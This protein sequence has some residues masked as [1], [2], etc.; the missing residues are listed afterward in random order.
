MSNNPKFKI[1]AF[2]NNATKLQE[3][4]EKRGGVAK[5]KSINLSNPGYSWSTP[6]LNEDGTPY[7]KPNWQCG[8]TPEIVTDPKEIGIIERELYKAIPVGL[9]RGDGLSFTLT[10][11][12][13]RKVHKLQEQC[14]K[15]HGDSFIERAVLDIEGASIGV[16]YTKSQTSL[17]D[18]I[19]Q[20]KEVKID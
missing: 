18:W 3:W 19:E 11:A 2:T 5:W 8:N 17:F 12:A 15:K 13:T 10:P 4:C 9:Q 16:Y 6:A 1:E 20:H 7:S 14:E